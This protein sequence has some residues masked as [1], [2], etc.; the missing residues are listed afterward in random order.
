MAPSSRIIKNKKVLVLCHGNIY[1]S[2]LCAAALSKHEGLSVRSA[3]FRSAGKRAARPARLAAAVLGYD[4]K[5]HRSS[6]VTPELLRWASFIIYMDSGNRR[7]LVDALVVAHLARP[8]ACLGQWSSPPRDRIP[9]LAF[10]FDKRDFLEHVAAIDRA[11]E[12]LALQL[13]SNTKLP[14][15]GR[16][17]TAS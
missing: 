14:S 17:T 15:F 16:N 6:L 12:L 7:R 1:R 9:D 13:I 10:V 11:S 4:L 5:T 3:G 8:Y 2:P